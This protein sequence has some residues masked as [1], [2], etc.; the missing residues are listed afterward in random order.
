MASGGLASRETWNRRTGNRSRRFLFINR[1]NFP[2]NQEM[3]GGG[4]EKPDSLLGGN[5]SR[6]HSRIKS[7]FLKSVYL[8]VNQQMKPCQGLEPL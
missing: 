6:P 3:P 5:R 1:K 7:H 8:T 4:G 2:K